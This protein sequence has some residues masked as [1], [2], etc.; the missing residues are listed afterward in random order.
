MFQNEEAHDPSW[1]EGTHHAK[2]GKK[3]IRPSWEAAR[4]LKT[5]ENLNVSER[6]E[7]TPLNHHPG[8]SHLLINRC[9]EDGEK[10]HFFSWQVLQENKGHSIQLF[11]NENK[12]KT[13]SAIQS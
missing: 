11:K 2:Q 12:M 4:I 1:R 7:R 8:S 13:F 10:S 5:K 6:K 9:P 3:Y